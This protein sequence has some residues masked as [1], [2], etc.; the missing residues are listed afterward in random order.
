MVIRIR[1]TISGPVPPAPASGASRHIRKRQLLPFFNILNYIALQCICGR[2][3]RAVGV[4][5]VIYQACLRIS[6]VTPRIP[7][8]IKGVERIAGLGT[9]EFE[10]F[11][12]GGGFGT[13]VLIVSLYLEGKEYKEKKIKNGIIVYAGTN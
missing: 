5:G 1:T 9:K 12:R 13:L 11:E 4:A 2:R 8:T 7:E 3:V 10:R 6:Y